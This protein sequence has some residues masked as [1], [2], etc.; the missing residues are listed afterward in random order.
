MTTFYAIRRA[1]YAL[2]PNRHLS[3]SV[4]FQDYLMNMARLSVAGIPVPEQNVALFRQL[5]QR[6]T[7]PG[8]K[9]PPALDPSWLQIADQIEPLVQEVAQS[10][11]PC[12]LEEDEIW[13]RKV[14]TYP[15]GRYAILR[16]GPKLAKLASAPPAELRSW[17]RSFGGSEDPID[18]ILAQGFANAWEQQDD[19]KDSDRLCS[20]E[21]E[22]Y[23]TLKTDNAQK[24][25]AILA[26]GLDLATARNAKNDTLG[27]SLIKSASR[28]ENCLRLLRAAEEKSSIW[29]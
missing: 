20:P 14:F 22:A 9:A 7:K 16:S 26:D 15:P 1:I 11:Q 5:I 28:A 27:Q 12:D 21:N 3:S 2:D 17:A 24:L 23:E 4:S 8:W 13:R 10:P 25:R 29:H 19:A 6:D 18:S